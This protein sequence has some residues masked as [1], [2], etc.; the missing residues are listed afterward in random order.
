[1][2]VPADVRNLTELCR[3]LQSESVNSPALNSLKSFF[4]LWMSLAL[5]NLELS[6]D[7]LRWE[8]CGSAV[9]L[10]SPLYFVLDLLLM[11]EV[12]D[13][14]LKLLSRARELS[15]S[16]LALT[17]RL[18]WSLLLLLPLLDRLCSKVYAVLKLSA[19]SARCFLDSDALVEGSATADTSF[20]LLEAELEW[21]LTAAERLVPPYFFLAHGEPLL[22]SLADLDDTKDVGVE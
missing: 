3:L 10:R 9:T 18:S 8:E 20:V 17:L 11:L 22:V 13:A 2:L 4:M 5:E 12:W 21:E 15:T 1:M 19:E 14:R 7:L 6:A 16:L